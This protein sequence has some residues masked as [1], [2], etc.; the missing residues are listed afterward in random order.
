[1]PSSPPLDLPPTDLLLAVCVQT[2]AALVAFAAGAAVSRALRERE[3]DWP[4]LL[5][6]LAGGLLAAWLI[7]GR[8][9]TF[10]AG[11]LPVPAVIVY[12]NP[13]PALGGLLAGLLAANRRV[14]GWRRAPL[15]AA[16]AA[17]G[18]YGPAS[19]LLHEPPAVRPVRRDGID[20]QTHRASCSAAAAATL[21]RARGILGF[22]EREMVRLCLTGER[23][24]PLLG[25]FRGLYLA[26]ERAGAPLRPVFRRMP[27][28]ELRAR[29]ELL[30]AMVS[31]RLTEEL[32]E[33]DPRY[34]GDWGWLLGVTHSV[35]VFRF[36]RD[37]RV[38]VGDPGAGRELWS[39]AALE[40]LW[41]GD[42][43]SLETPDPG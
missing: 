19:T 7:A 28:A 5:A 6:A 3:A 36:T 23:G 43:L 37:G 9:P 41:V 26:A 38:E 40:S 39:V 29:P 22:T 33:R 32:D 8:E 12:G 24:T 20:M 30:P 4:L 18:L 34:R 27:A 1:M 15:A 11:W 10:V 17:V 25:A 14:P 31:V 42:V 21:L 35:V 16:V 13:G 2:V